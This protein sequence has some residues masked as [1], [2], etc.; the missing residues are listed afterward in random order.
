MLGSTANGARIDEM[1]D[2]PKPLTTVGVATFLDVGT[3]ISET[4]YIQER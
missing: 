4:D 2:Q 1:A 3:S